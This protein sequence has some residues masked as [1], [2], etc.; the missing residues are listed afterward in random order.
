MLKILLHTCCAPCGAYVIEQLQ[1]QGHAA[2]V[3]FTNDN[4]YPQAEYERRQEEIKKYCQIQGVE[5]LTSDYHPE[6]WLAAVKGLENEPEGGARCLVCFRYRLAKT[7]HQAR[8]IGCDFFASTLSISPHK[9][10]A[11]VNAVGQ[12]VSEKI[13]VPFL[14]ADW[15]ENNGFQC[16]CELSHQH[17]FYRQNY[18]GCQFS[19]RKEE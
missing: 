8:A 5:F 7:A 3:F 1:K 12:E 19:L 15:K 13:G 2:V 6:A 9:N 18:C 17:Q 16:S 11:V 4:I 10:S 14:A